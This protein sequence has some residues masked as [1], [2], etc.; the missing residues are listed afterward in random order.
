MTRGTIAVVA[1]MA[2]CARHTAGPP[3]VVEP[4]VGPGASVVLAWSAPVDL[5][6]YVTDPTGITFYYAKPGGVLAAETRCEGMRPGAHAER[7]YIPRAAAGRYRV[8]VDFPHA[9][10]TRMT[11][12]PFRIVVTAAGRRHEAS[13]TARLGERQPLVLEFDVEAR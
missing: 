8:G 12:V 11:T 6:L 7:A 9:C 3:A 5:D 1:L 10:G 4:D 2:A 13:G